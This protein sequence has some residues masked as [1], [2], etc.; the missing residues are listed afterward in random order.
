MKSYPEITGVGSNQNIRILI[1]TPCYLEGF[2]DDV[3]L[4]GEEDPNGGGGAAATKPIITIEFPYTSGACS[5][6][7]ALTALPKD[8]TCHHNNALLTLPK[9]PVIS[10][11]HDDHHQANN[12]DVKNKESQDPER[13]NDA[14]KLFNGERSNWGEGGLS[15]EEGQ[16]PGRGIY[17]AE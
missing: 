12:G 4:G 11:N 16:P 8:S 6:G 9:E 2:E 14:D 5:N 17:T 13:H 1:R 7:K 3:F 10:Q 15:R